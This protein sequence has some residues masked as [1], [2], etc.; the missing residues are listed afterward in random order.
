[1]LCWINALLT[2]IFIPNLSFHIVNLS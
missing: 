1:V 2:T